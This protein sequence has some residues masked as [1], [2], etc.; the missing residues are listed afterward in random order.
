MRIASRILLA[1]PSLCR[2]AVHP[3]ASHGSHMVVAA[4]GDPVSFVGAV[5][6]RSSRAAEGLTSLHLAVPASVLAGYTVPGQFLQVR[7]AEGD[8][9]SF[10]AIASPVGADPQAGVELLVRETPSTAALCGLGAGAALQVSPVQGRGFAVGAL[11]PPSSFPNVL[12]FATGS[13][14]SPVAALL[15]T[16]GALRAAER[17]GV[18]LFL[19]VRSPAHLPWGDR[20]DAWRASGVRITT[21]FSSVEGR[22]V[23]DA[24]LAAGGVGDAATT[25]A[26][27]VGQKAMAETLT[28]TLLAAGVPMERILTNY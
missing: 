4:W 12:L 15:D 18:H 23:Q 6:T 25:G 16:P 21:V 9:P 3:F 8:K 24:F 28:A 22:Y 19:G 20:L 1:R 10:M 14:V 11:H 5:V 13:G 26:V 27:L 7:V 17:G 2:R